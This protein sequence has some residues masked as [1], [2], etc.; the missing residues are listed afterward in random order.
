M[1]LNQGAILP[2][3]RYLAISGDTFDH[4]EAKDAVKHPSI[5]QKAS[6]P[7]QRIIVS[8]RQ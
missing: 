2:T 3:K 6:L 8:I 7:Q 4:H 1:I 5:H